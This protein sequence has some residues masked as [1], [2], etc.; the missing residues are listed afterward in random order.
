MIPKQSD[1]K[2]GNRSIV[3]LSKIIPMVQDHFS[4]EYISEEIVL[5]P[6]LFFENPVGIRIA[7][8]IYLCRKTVYIPQDG[9]LH[10][11]NSSP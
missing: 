9:S 11:S 7:G 1:H 8:T 4:A 10:N 6:I 2:P 5:C 3:C